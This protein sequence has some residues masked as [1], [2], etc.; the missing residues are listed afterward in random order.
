MKLARREKKGP[1]TDACCN[2]EYTVTTKKP[3]I[4][5]TVEE[6][7]T[8]ELGKP[9]V[10]EKQRKPTQTEDAISGN[11]QQGKVISD[12]IVLEATEGTGLE[13]ENGQDPLAQVNNSPPDSPEQE[14][15]PKRQRHPPAVL[16]YNTLGNLPCDP[17]CCT[18]HSRQQW[19]W[20]SI[21]PV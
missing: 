14:P 4:G 6:T 18:R 5:Q 15:S 9:S 19:F 1:Y 13:N 8:K 11:A 21:T 12:H 10:K 16:T 17:I 2:D 3:H 7:V 20:T